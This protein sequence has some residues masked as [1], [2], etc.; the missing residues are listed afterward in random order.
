MT[1]NLPPY[2]IAIFWDRGF[3]NVAIKRLSG[4]WDLVGTGSYWFDTDEELFEAW[5]TVEIVGE[6][7][8]PEKT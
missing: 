4:H 8:W 7:I 5:P 3:E 6:G 1:S 2:T